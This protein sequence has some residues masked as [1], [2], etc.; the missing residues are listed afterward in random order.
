MCEGP[1]TY[2]L[3]PAGPGIWL[4]LVEVPGVGFNIFFYYLNPYMVVSLNRGTPI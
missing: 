3:S 2:R 4:E 1:G